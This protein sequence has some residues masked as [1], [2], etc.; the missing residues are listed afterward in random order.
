LSSLCIIIIIIIYYLFCS[1]PQA[2]MSWGA[3]YA[4]LGGV[5]KHSTSLSKIWLSV[6]FIFRIPILVLA[7][8]SVWGNELSG[9]MCNTKQPGCT[10]LCYD[11]F[12]PMSHIRLWCLQLIFVSMPALLVAMHAA[13]RKHGGKRSMLA[14]DDT[15]KPSSVDME[16][17]KR[18]RL[19]ITGTL[20]WTYTCS[21]FF[22]LIFEGGFMLLALPTPDGLQHFW[23]HEKTIFTILMVASSIIC[24]LLNLA[25]LGYLVC[26]ALMRRSGQR[27]NRR[28][29]YNHKETVARDGTALQ[30]KKNELPLSAPSWG[31]SVRK[32]MC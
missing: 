24:M 15:E 10:Y 7:A 8:K 19:P 2:I 3:L 31:S 9:F 32:T 16:T 6:L 22:R 13:Y 30:N 20:W 5:N 12:F 25:E 18:R 17:L 4:Q 11:H 28:L 26:K 1:P 21:L 29:S 14:S 27:Q 23:A